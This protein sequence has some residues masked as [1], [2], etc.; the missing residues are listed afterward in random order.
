VTSDT[1]TVG[2]PEQEQISYNRDPNFNY[3][4]SSTDTLGRTTAYSY[5]SLAN[6]TAITRLAETS[7]AVTT[8]YT[9]DPVF[10]Q[11]TSVT[12][13]LGHVWTL[14]RDSNGNLTG[15]S[16]PLGHQATA[17]YNSEGQITAVTDGAGDTIG[18][19]YSGADLAS[20]TDALGNSTN[21][22]H[23]GAGR[24][25]QFTDP[26]GGLTLLS[27]DAL[28][29]LIQ[30]TNALDGVTS[31][32]YDPDGN[33][34]TV[35]DANGGKTTYTYNSMDRR[36]SRTDPLGA[37]ETYAYDG[38]S[39]LAQHTDRRGKVTV[40][41]YDGLNR[42]TFAG[43]GYNGSG[44]ESTIG[45][46]WDGGDRLTA[47]TDSI[48]GT[49]ARTYDGLDDLTDEQTPQGEVSY[50]YDSARR[51]TSMTVAG[52]NAVSYTWDNANR[53][54]NIAQGSSSIAFNFDNA[55][56]RTQLT[57]PN[58]VTVAYGYDSNS[59]VTAMTWTLAGNPVG[60]LE[61]SYDA[62]GHVIEK[63]GSLNQTSAPQPLTGNTFNA[64]NEMAAFNGTALTYDTNGNL[65]NDGT[66]TYTWDARNHLSAISGVNTAAFVYDPFER[67]ASKTINGNATQ[68]LYDG[69]NPV[70][71]LQNGSPSANLLTGLGIDQYLER[72]DSAGARDFIT[73]ILGN[74]LA[75]SDASGTLQTTYTYDPFGNTTSAGASNTSSF[76]F[77]GRENDG[78]GLYFYR[79]RYYSPTFQRFIAQDPTGFDGR[80][81]NLYGYVYDDPVNLL[82][83]W[84]LWGVGFTIGGSAEG[85]AGAGTAGTSELGFGVFVNGWHVSFGE[86]ATAGGFSGV[87]G[88]EASLTGG[89]NGLAF[90][91]G[92]GGGLSFFATNANCVNDLSKNFRT[93][94]VDAG[95]GPLQGSGQLSVGHNSAGQPIVQGSFSPPIF[96]E[97]FGAG[98]SSMTTYTQVIGSWSAF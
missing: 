95:I 97:T 74:T 20:V 25:T 45:Y 71:E 40:Y 41:Q 23:D 61:Y 91:G 50:A 19:T 34:L 35:T 21:L 76:Q 62:D 15:I 53:L 49:I 55:N 39:N 27:Y 4:L 93:E 59:R 64:D 29:D 2:A 16:D 48:A 26:L 38:N 42:Q 22:L 88:T 6:L 13:A 79:A 12:D 78:T 94:T 80:D 10:S 98:A 83:P 90:G 73:D 44:Y 57:L 75:L 9:Y 96:G 67:R 54:S 81:A 68:F 84:G 92:A 46:T 1:E 56:R 28:G 85:G 70:Q 87:P 47:A 72:T 5:D 18:F 36:V 86:F 89:S 17:T 58:G 52:Q 77:T 43:F 3:I 8:S 33:L 30:S 51:R 11:V 24:L 63:S 14:S 69:L 37:S 66:N 32:G 65:A 31:F 7:Q 82:D 60:D